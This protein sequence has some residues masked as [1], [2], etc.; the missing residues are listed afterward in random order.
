VVGTKDELCK[1]A[2][3]S[4]R[5]AEERRSHEVKA[6]LRAAVA[7]ACWQERVVGST[8][9]RA[10]SSSL[11]TAAPQQA[12]HS[13]TGPTRR[14]AAHRSRGPRRLPRVRREHPRPWW[15]SSGPRPP[16]LK[17][18]VRV[19]RRAVHVERC[20]RARREGRQETHGLASG[21]AMMV[22]RARSEGSSTGCRNSTR[23][24]GKAVA[25]ALTTL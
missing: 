17:G 13:L 11:V 19:V 14:I 22:S 15:S 2:W 20:L 9:L 23:R 10:N 4:D 7:A 12:R 24:P 25:H 3:Y 8:L 5:G 1:T 21:P 16:L 6:M 18:L